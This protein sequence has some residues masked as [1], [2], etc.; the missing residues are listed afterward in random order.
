MTIGEQKTLSATT[1][2]GYIWLGWFDGTTKVSVD[3]NYVFTM[4]RES[5][6]FTARWEK[7]TSHTLVECVCT[8][9]NA[10]SHT[11][12]IIGGVCNSF[13]EVVYTRDG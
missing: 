13:N 6:V 1:N 12:N 2:P 8:K 7:C 10:V 4:D 9:C 11:G 3:E 5:K